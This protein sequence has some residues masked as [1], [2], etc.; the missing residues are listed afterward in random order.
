MGSS[1]R[2]GP[3][4]R[5]PR[6]AIL[7]WGA[8]WIV[9]LLAA[10]SLSVLAAAN[11][12]L[13]GD[14]AIVQWA[15]DLPVPGLALSRFVRLLSGTEVVLGTGAVVALAL[16]LSRRREARPTGRQALLLALGLLLLP[17][18]QHELKEIVDRPRPPADLVD[19]RAGFSSPSFPAGHVMSPTLLYGFLLYLS[20]RGI[21]G[22]PLGLA[23]LAASLFMLVLAGPA[24]VYVG[25]H[26]PSD[27]VGGYA[28]GLVLLLP[29][30][31]LDALAA[32]SD[33]MFPRTLRM[34]H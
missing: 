11:D 31:G 29:L 13:P 23:V 10:V 20:L 4:A 2:I 22:R 14:L 16:W 15:Q 1:M 33:P 28:W 30:L 32:G 21:P 7:L 25:V 9:L 12:R 8:A 24:N 19:L 18:L 17:L 26:W 27:V 5:Q 3:I 6:T 34:R